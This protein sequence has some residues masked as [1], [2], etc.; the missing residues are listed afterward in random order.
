[1]AFLFGLTTFLY[2][3]LGLHRNIGVCLCVVSLLNV[4]RIYCTVGGAFREYYEVCLRDDLEDIGRH[5][6]LVRDP[7]TRRLSDQQ[8]LQPSSGSGFWVAE[9]ET[10][11]DWDIIGCVGLGTVY[12]RPSS[13]V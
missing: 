1:M 12:S 4:I 9:V 13:K 8:D 5:Y 6:G 3:S 10:E 2:S 7:A 11:H